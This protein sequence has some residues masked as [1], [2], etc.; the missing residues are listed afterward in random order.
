MNCLD[1]VSEVLEEISVVLRY[2]GN[3]T[4]GS[5]TLLNIGII[6]EHANEVTQRAVLI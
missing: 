6:L 3:Q 1:R 5:Q 4:V 2:L